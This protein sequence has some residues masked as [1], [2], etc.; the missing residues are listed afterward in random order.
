MNLDHSPNDFDL[1]P[2]RGGYDEVYCDAR[3]ASQFP[4]GGA[5]RQMRSFDRWSV[6]RLPLTVAHRITSVRPNTVTLVIRG[7]KSRVWGF[8]PPEGF[9]DQHRY[10]YATRRPVHEER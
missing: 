1:P 5:L 8:Y 10:D 3:T 4:L 7:P 6:H 9:V 2:V